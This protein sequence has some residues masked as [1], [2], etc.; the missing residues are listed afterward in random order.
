MN[1]RAG[2]ASLSATS[3]ASGFVYRLD[4]AFAFAFDPQ[5]LASDLVLHVRHVFDGAAVHQDT[6]AD[7]D[8]LGNAHLL[9]AHR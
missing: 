7:D 1:E 6:L 4:L 3:A 2:L 5:D 9:R 8:L